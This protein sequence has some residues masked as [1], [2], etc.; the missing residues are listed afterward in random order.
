MERF[1][2]RSPV[3]QGSG[4]VTVGQS[5]GGACKGVDS[6]EW[7]TRA[8]LA[9]L[10]HAES[11]CMGAKRKRMEE[12]SSDDDCNKRLHMAL[13]V[14]VTPALEP[15]QVTH[16][17]PETLL[18]CAA[19]DVQRVFLRCWTHT[20]HGYRT[21]RG[22]V[23]G[24]LVRSS[25][26]RLWTVQR[27]RRR[28]NC[29]RMV[30]LRVEVPQRSTAANTLLLSLPRRCIRFSSRSLDLGR[31]VLVVWRHSQALTDPLVGVCRCASCRVSRHATPSCCASGLVSTVNIGNTGW[32]DA[33]RFCSIA[34]IWVHVNI[35]QLQALHTTSLSSPAARW[36]AHSLVVVRCSAPRAQQPRAWSSVLAQQA[37]AT[38]HSCGILD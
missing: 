18:A 5:T 16:H 2:Q 22:R 1:L 33:V 9:S 13:R 10:R 27:R 26:S 29:L 19:A 37:L 25:A 35:L 7:D 17:R 34:L 32:Q 36:H 11:I 38:S 8:M 12:Q 23:C 30:P 28:S 15:V 31:F 21:P 3:S 14:T 20:V 24:T 6:W 4:T